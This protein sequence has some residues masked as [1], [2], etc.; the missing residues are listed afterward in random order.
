[1]NSLTGTRKQISFIEAVAS[2][3]LETFHSKAI[4]WSLNQIGP[5]VDFASIL[6]EDVH[7]SWT[8]IVTAA[9]VRS[10]DLLTLFKRQTESGEDVLGLILWENKVKADFH[11]KPISKLPKSKDV[12]ITA[13]LENYERSWKRGVS[14]PIWYQLRWVLWSVSQRNQLLRDAFPGIEGL[15]A[16]N[17]EVHWRIL[18]P[19]QEDLLKE[20]HQTEWIGFKGVGQQT[21]GNIAGD[22]CLLEEVTS[23]SGQSCQP[24]GFL[25]FRN[26]IEAEHGLAN[27]EFVQGNADA[28]S[29]LREEYFRY[30]KKSEY[31]EP[32]VLSG[33]GWSVS[34]LL[35]LSEELRKHGV[36]VQ[37]HWRVGGSSNN[38]AP[39]LN[40]SF[41]PGGML[42]HVSDKA[43]ELNLQE[44]LEG[45]TTGSFID[46]IDCCIQLQGDAVK[47]QFAHK[48]YNSVK[49]RS[50]GREAYRDKVMG[51]FF[52]EKAR[53]CNS[54]FWS[55]K[56]T[57]M[58]LEGSNPIFEVSRENLPSTKTGLSYSLCKRDEGVGTVAI[59]KIDEMLSLCQMLQ[60][61]IETN[62]RMSMLYD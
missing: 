9:E 7:E 16:S 52:R 50:G 38:G 30:L 56:V 44:E 13:V 46:F 14:Q 57:E 60:A 18:S 33:T 24:W 61:H 47:L 39:L 35:R 62:F 5:G 34:K 21:D 54:E 26:L 48:D 2:S 27:A 43:N 17:L 3:D 55:G 6:G 4:A 59:S 31:F 40:L 41:H 53:P 45:L 29:V 49:M 25:T 51:A 58:F 1:M 19:F 22:L 15:E 42:D 10:H 11:Q 32:Q 23:R 20:F 36:L 8:H 28:S 37:R 12:E